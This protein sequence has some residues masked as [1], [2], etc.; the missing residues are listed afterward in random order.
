METGEQIHWSLFS[1]ARMVLIGSIPHYRCQIPIPTRESSNKREVFGKSW[2]TLASITTPSGRVSCFLQHLISRDSWNLEIFTSPI[3]D[4]NFHCRHIVCLFLM[5][6]EI[7]IPRRGW[8]QCGIDSV[9]LHRVPLSWASYA[10]NRDEGILL[11]GCSH[12][13]LPRCPFSHALFEQ[14]TFLSWQR[15]FLPLMIWANDMLSWQSTDLLL[16]KSFGR[17]KILL[18]SGT[19]F[20]STCNL[21]FWVEQVQISG[22]LMIWWLLKMSTTITWIY[23]LVLTSQYIVIIWI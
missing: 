23:H 5:I 4:Q 15:K 20:M 8:W 18:P 11:H 13:Q 9:Q 6:S 16:E 21:F 14:K 22:L 12:Q 17:S 19:N 2:S 1:F 10:S 3:I 7:N